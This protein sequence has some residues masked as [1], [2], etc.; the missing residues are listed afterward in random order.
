MSSSMIIT[1]YYNINNIVQF[2]ILSG[3]RYAV[4][5]YSFTWL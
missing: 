2:L 5:T 3:H 4:M 1:D